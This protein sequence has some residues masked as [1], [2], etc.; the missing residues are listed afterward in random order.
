MGQSKLVYEHMLNRPIEDISDSRVANGTAFDSFFATD[1]D[2]DPETA[3]NNVAN[4]HRPKVSALSLDH[5]I[6]LRIIK[7][8][9]VHHL[10]IREVAQLVGMNA[11]AVNKRIQRIKAE[12]PHVQHLS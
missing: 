9:F 7:L 4:M 1:P 10:K 12:H 11:E 6:N 3:E 5:P 8:R 2:D